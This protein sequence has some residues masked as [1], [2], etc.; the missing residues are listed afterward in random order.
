VSLATKTPEV[1]DAVTALYQLHRDDIY[2]YLLR[3]DLGSGQAMDLC[4]E[5]FF[6]LFRALHDDGQQIENPRGWL[7]RVAHN[8]GLN[9][10]VSGRRNEAWDD[11]LEARVASGE[12]NPEQELLEK[13]KF[14]CIHR[15]VDGLT[16]RQRHCLHL[17][18]E[19]FR[20]HEIAE[21]MGIST[22]NVNEAVREALKRIRKA[23]CE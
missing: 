9:A 21:I 22:S 23:L 1:R 14:A 4:Q 12:P 2:R 18:N 6:R 15:A 16:D 7:F 10:K 19:G 3:L 5:T 13:E 17:R 11:T 8:A 20:Y